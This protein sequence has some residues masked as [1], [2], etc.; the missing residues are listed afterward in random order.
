MKLF[1]NVYILAV[2]SWIRL[3]R[4]KIIF[5]ASKGQ[6]IVKFGHF[7]TFWQCSQ[8]WVFFSNFHENGMIFC[9]CIPLLGDDI[10]QFLT[11][12]YGR[13]FE[14]CSSLLQLYLIPFW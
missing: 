10:D 13:E 9:F 4:S 2:K 3:N 11:V 8:I 12:E 5:Q 1:W 6:K 7:A 14:Q